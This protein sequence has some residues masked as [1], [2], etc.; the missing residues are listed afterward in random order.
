MNYV[1]MF[2]LDQLYR[3]ESNFLIGVR[4]YIADYQNI[5]AMD[6][7]RQIGFLPFTR[8]MDINFENF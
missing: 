5:I 4:D 8:K 7:S 2:N 1:N 3:N 6:Y